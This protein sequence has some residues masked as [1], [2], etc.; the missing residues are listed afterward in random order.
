MKQNDLL[1]IVIVVATLGYLATTLENKKPDPDKPDCVPC[2]PDVEPYT[3]RLDALHS[4]SRDMTAE[5][6]RAMYLTFDAG[7]R[8]VEADVEKGQISTS[9]KAQDFL[10]SLLVFDFNG[11]TPPSK[12]YPIVSEEIEKS[13]FS[14]VG[15][16]ARSFSSADRRK[17]S[18]ELS[19]IAKA[20]R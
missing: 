14:V 12:R 10:I 7:S 15:D 19:E 6:R 4:A 20:V 5:D 17:L 13:F 9:N 1:R 8:M 16:E 2:T 18:E 3:G 11:V